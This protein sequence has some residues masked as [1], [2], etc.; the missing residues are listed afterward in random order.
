[1]FY[2][3]F[4]MFVYGLYDLQNS[5]QLEHQHQF[6]QI[7]GNV[8]ECFHTTFDFI[9]RPFIGN[10]YHVK[11]GYKT[12]KKTKNTL[13]SIECMNNVEIEVY[14]RELELGQT[15]ILTELKNTFNYKVLK[16]EKSEKV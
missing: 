12:D 7:D 11:V 8:H 14:I 13:I 5:I 15:A 4:I 10:M 1:M 6:W 3:V 2:F 9:C 16:D